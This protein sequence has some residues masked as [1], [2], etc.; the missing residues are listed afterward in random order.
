MVA[1]RQALMLTHLSVAS[2]WALGQ[3]TSLQAAGAHHARLPSA[4]MSMGDPGGALTLLG[5]AL[6]RSSD[7]AE[8]SRDWQRVGNQWL[9]L[10]ASTPWA[11]VHFVGGAGLGS[12]P[13]LCYN[14]L[15]ADVCDRAN[16]AVIA[17]PYDVAPDHARLAA[18]CMA[19]FE[20]ARA[21]ACELGLLPAAA[22][23]F[24]AGHS[25]GAKLLVVEACR[26]AGEAGDE[27]YTGSAPQPAPL[28]LLAYNNFG[29]ADSV[30]LASSVVQTMQGGG[31]R[32]GQTASAIADAFAFA[33]QM[34][35]A[36]GFN[37]EFSPSPSELQARVATSYS[38]PSTRLFRFETSDGQRDDL[39]CSEE[40]MAS[41]Q[42][43]SLPSAGP[44]ERIVERITL[45]GTHLA[46]A[47]VEVDLSELDATLAS[48]LGARTFSLGDEAAVR[49][50]ADA[51]VTW[52]WPG[53]MAPPPTRALQ[54]SELGADVDGA[55]D[56]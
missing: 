42:N 49:A 33:Q 28:G 5:G 8:S 40:L 39:D 44:A 35:G 26:V 32:A 22:P 25:L 24:R 55:I 31:G 36:S 29:V 23:V 52:L 27:V 13:Q 21:E 45:P 51:L 54:A 48:L 14:S 19:G 18:E 50:A 2:C 1:V 43:C 7:S 47:S 37:L 10:P 3:P 30:R 20:S 38:A 15:W 6:A 34:G 56:V 53:G 17:T 12:A 41:I 9:R 4:T 11:V 16:V 46:P